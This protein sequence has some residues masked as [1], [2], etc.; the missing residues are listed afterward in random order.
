MGIRAERTAAF[1]DLQDSF[2]NSKRR[3]VF[4][5]NYL[6]WGGAQVYFLAIMKIA[7]ENWKIIVHLPK[8]SSPEMIGY[9]KNLDVEYKLFDHHLNLDP[10]SGV[11][12]KVERQIN[13]MKVEYRTF[14]SLL[15]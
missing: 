2:M 8:A 15:E 3:L 1:R 9:L 4:V 5:W 11:G 12:G 6:N 7:K 14:R 10:V 13:R